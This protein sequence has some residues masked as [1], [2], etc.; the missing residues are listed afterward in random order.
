M[1]AAA[2]EDPIRIAH[3]HSDGSAGASLPPSPPHAVPCRGQ[4]DAIS[5]PPKSCWLDVA[6]PSP[7]LICRNTA[8]S[9]VCLQGVAQT[10]AGLAALRGQSLSLSR[11][12]R[13]GLLLR[14]NC[15][16]G[17]QLHP[18]SVTALAA[19]PPSTARGTS[20]L[21][22][23][24]FQQG[25]SHM[26]PTQALARCRTWPQCRR[27]LPALMFSSLSR[28]APV[29]VTNRCLTAARACLPQSFYS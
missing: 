24:D 10:P 16:G 20:K 21:G 5:V 26:E 9:C 7:K 17:A 19:L 23:W 13:R 18:S 15:A 2:W 29:H 25:G 11:A 4:T 22:T 27:T 28:P 12:A 3:G 6:S 1:Q 8:G 14:P